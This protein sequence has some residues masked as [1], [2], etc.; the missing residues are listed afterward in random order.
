MAARRTEMDRL[1]ELVR[2]H[3]LNSGGREVARLLKMSPNTERKYRLA[4]ETAG[5][6]HGCP[7]QLPGLDELKEAVLAACPVSAPPP[8]ERSGI[9]SWR[10]KVEPLLNAGLTP[11]VV[12]ER[13]KER[14]PDFTGS[15]S[16]VKRMCRTLRRERGVLAT[17][18]AIPVVTLPGKEAQVDFGYIGKLL[19]PE[20]D[21]LRRAWCFVMV[22]SHSRHMCV[23]VVFDQTIET[24]LKVHVSCFEELGG[25]PEIVRPD[26]LKAA[27][28]N[29]AFTPSQ[30]TTLNRSY[31]ELARHYG[32]KSDPTPPYAPQKKG[33]VESGVKYAKNSF[34]KGRAGQRVDQVRAALQQWSKNIAGQ[35]THGT[36]GKRPAVAF[37][38]EEL[39][40]MRPLPEARFELVK[41][42]QAK[43]HRDAHIAFDKRL[44]SVPWRLVGKQVWVRATKSTVFVFADDCRVA[45]HCR[46]GTERR[47]TRDAH[48]PE[49]RGNYRSRPSALGRR[50]RRDG[51]AGGSTGAR[52]LRRRRRALRRADGTGDA[53]T[54]GRHSCRA[55]QSDLHAGELLWDHSLR[56]DQTHREQATRP[57]ATSDRCRRW[58]RP[59]E[60]TAIRARSERPDAIGA[61]RWAS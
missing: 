33:K 50:G 31:R 30:S 4:L 36:T 21:S 28:I 44:Y 2:L 9:E 22:L 13:L 29:A 10:S 3:R 12:W 45:T 25:V 59:I 40:L 1:Q 54:A 53:A 37:A 11:K 38:E 19:D 52:D 27:V 47:S 20:T 6:L 5:L 51:S 17:D 60:P 14:E 23:R 18:V 57:R 48:L 34:F 16:Q 32:F 56:R 42:A 55:H 15:Y 26:N 41:W 7:K 39:P 46:I 58:S 43:V 49:G 8:Q 61:R 24:W 35:R